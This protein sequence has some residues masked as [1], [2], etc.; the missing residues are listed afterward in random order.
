MGLVLFIDMDY[1]FAACEELRHPE[2]KSKAFV[3]G[4]S[5]IAKKEKGVVQTCNYAARKFGIHS[6][7]PTAQALRLKPDLVYLESDDEYYSMVSEKVMALLKGYGFPTEVVSIDEAALDLGETSYESAEELAKRIKGKIKKEIG[8]PC[9]IGVSTGKNYAKMVC[10]DSKPNG[11]GILKGEEVV[12]YLKDKKVEKMLGV[13][14]KT[15]E[16]L[17]SMGI[18]KIGEIANADPN[19]LVER[20]GSFG[21]E[22]YLLSK[23]I[24]N[25]KVVGSA[26]VLSVGRERTLEKESRSAQDI[27]RM[28]MELSKEVVKEL[29]KQGLWFKGVSVKA[30]YS[31]FTERIK[32]RKL[33]NHTDSLDTL[34]GTAA[35]LMKELVGEKYVRK[36]G[37]RTYLLEKR[38][39]QRKI[40]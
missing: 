28:L 9:T 25:S 37:V 6:A 31:D 39:G 3:V 7:M 23:G 36:V 19:L 32:N 1:F 2:L 4:T 27:E 34:Y 15:A 13:G 10:D 21:K 29:G 24:D 12:P 16:R 35:Q 17:A 33:N 40:L 22:L 5:T 8:L 26:S 38:A 20:L 14:R 11:I 18:E 30:R